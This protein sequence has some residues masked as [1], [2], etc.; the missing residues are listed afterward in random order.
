MLPSLGLTWS[1][2]MMSARSF[3]DILR[4]EAAMD[5]ALIIDLDERP[6][7]AATE[8]ACRSLLQLL[9]CCLTS[10]TSKSISLARVWKQ[11]GW[12]KKKRMMKWIQK[13][14]RDS[15]ARQMNKWNWSSMRQRGRVHY[16]GILSLTHTDSLRF[17][18]TLPCRNV[19]AWGSC[20]VDWELREQR[21]DIKHTLSLASFSK[22]RK[23][24]Y[25]EK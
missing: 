1:V 2:S 5:L 12:I 13:N 11:A 16:E 15:I 3:S 23:S 25:R 24:L 4:M 19:D 10:S 18:F 21:F 7:F 6:L 14:K 17:C 8:L 20:P 9:N 22:G